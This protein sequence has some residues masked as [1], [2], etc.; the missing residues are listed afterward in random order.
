MSTSFT[1]ILTKG[2]QSNLANTP[3]ENGKLRFAYDTGRVFLDNNNIRVEITDFCK[4]Y[5]EAGIKS[6]LSPLPKVYIASDTNKM[7]MY[8]SENEKW[9]YLSGKSSDYAT[10][11]GTAVYATNAGTAEYAKSAGTA[12]RAVND[13]KGN[14]FLANYAPLQSPLFTGI[15]SVPTPSES[16][17]DTQIANTEYVTTAIANA[18]SN[19][20]GFDISIIKDGESLPETGTKGVFYLVANSSEDGDNSYDEY[21][22]IESTSSYEH[23]G[24][25]E[26]D[27]DGYFN[28][29][30]V[31]GTG[32]A[33]TS[34]AISEDGSQL[35][36][37]KD[38]SFLTKHPSV[39]LSGQSTYNYAPGA[40]NSFTAIDTVSLDEYGHVK[41]YRV[42]TITMPSAVSSVSY[43]SNAGTASYAKSGPTYIGATTAV[44]GTAGLVPSA[45][46]MQKALFLRGDGV[47]AAPTTPSQV[48]HAVYAQ[49]GVQ[50]GST[51]STAGY[52]GLLW[53]DTSAGST[54][55]VLKYRTSTSSTAWIS[56]A[57]V[58]S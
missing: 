25:H 21:I 23:I 46:T 48:T 12:S 7:M 37:S 56:V 33:I 4:D 11:A 36:F 49:N 52:N 24:S 53:V 57:S 26:V 17:N 22:W 1:K 14:G 39:T 43:A 9:I 2:L 3:I 51:A 16:S 55:A 29:I 44:A 34:V 38:N 47:W 8:D 18:V 19:I 40:G 31:S 35:N 28:N 15:P 41:S 20:T 54:A 50:V 58:W 10:N 30:S 27:I 5:T 6:I 13:A 32:N 45:T 42:K